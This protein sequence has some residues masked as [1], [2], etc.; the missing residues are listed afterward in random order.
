[1]NLSELLARNGRKYSGKTAV[2]EKNK[3]MTYGELDRQVTKFAN[4]LKNL[5]VSQGDKV[6]LFM[7]NT[8]SFLITYFA[9]LRLGG[10]I[11]PVSARLTGEELA[12]MLSHSEAK[13]MVIDHILYNSCASLPAKFENV[14]FVKT[15]EKVEGWGSFESLLNEGGNTPIECGTKEDDLATMLYT[16]GTTGKPKGVLFS[17]R[18]ILSVAAMMAV[19]MEMKPESKMLHMMPL[20]H[21]APLHLFLAAG[22]Y[23]G[24]THCLS[25]TFT[26]ELLLESVEKWRTTHFFG[27]PVAYL[28]SAKDPSINERDLSSMTHWVYGGA[29]L[30]KKEVTFMQQAFKSDRFYCVYGLTEAGPNGTL[31]LPEEHEEKAGSIGRRAALNAEIKLV[32]EQGEEVNTGEPGEIILRGEGNM[33]RYDKEPEK[34]AET[35]KDGWLFTGDMAKRDEDGYYWVIDRKKDMIISGG[36]NIFPKEIEEVLSTHPA[37]A[38]CAVIGAPHEDWGETVT[39]YIAVKDGE[40]ADESEWKSFLQEKVADYKIPKHFHVIDQL[41]RNPTGKILKHHL[42]KNHV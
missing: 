15:G 31:L 27:A 25:P 11:V 8:S 18:N 22:T 33:V 20:S 14:V 42:R 16:S 3:D 5:G 30:G 39:A 38:E 17:N 36:V 7:P 23:V 40:S 32:N 19:E 9:T 35:L 34:T 10:I 29:P 2:Q 1:M 21:S 37:V 24:A 41:P 28:L 12:Y 6:M 13:V 4:G 26:P